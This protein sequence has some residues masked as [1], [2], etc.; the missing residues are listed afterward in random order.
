MLVWNVLKRVHLGQLRLCW[1][2]LDQGGQEV[3]SKGF[4]WLLPFEELQYANILFANDLWTEEDE[5]EGSQRD[6]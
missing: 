6:I 1:F 3:R 4:E 2:V 5:W